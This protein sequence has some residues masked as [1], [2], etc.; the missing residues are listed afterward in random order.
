MIPLSASDRSGLYKAT[1]GCRMP[2]TGRLQTGTGRF[3]VGLRITHLDDIMNDQLMMMMLCDS[4]E[5]VFH[6]VGASPVRKTRNTC[7]DSLYHKD[8][9]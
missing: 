2:C 9:I 7:S 5:F 4:C 1:L 6:R 3:G 8:V